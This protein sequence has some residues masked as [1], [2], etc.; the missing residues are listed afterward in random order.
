MD[1]SDDSINILRLLKSPTPPPSETA[2]PLGSAT[3]VLSSTPPDTAPSAVSSSRPMSPDSIILD[4]TGR[5]T[6]SHN[7]L[8]DGVPSVRPHSPDSL[9]SPIP[10]RVSSTGSLTSDITDFSDDSINILRLL[11][12]PTPPPS[13]TARPLGSATNVLTSTPPDTAPSAV[14]SSRPMSPDSIILDLTGRDTPSHNSLADGVPSVRPHSPDSLHSP[15]PSRVPSTGSLTSDITDS[16]DTATT[17]AF[18]QDSLELD[19]GWESHGRPPSLSPFHPPSVVVEMACN[20]NNNNHHHLTGTEGHSRVTNEVLIGRDL[21][22]NNLLVILVSA[23]VLGS[24]GSMTAINIHV[25]GSPTHIV[26]EWLT[27][28]ATS[29]VLAAASAIVVAATCTTYSVMSSYRSTHQ[30]HKYSFNSSTIDQT[31]HLEE[32][33]PRNTRNQK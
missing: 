19:D 18:S 14:S 27:R 7:S 8:V 6:P 26:H 10:S 24:V 29:M 20:H 2:R 21:S 16:F 32:F 22:M 5:D 33:K 9:H 31:K 11:K 17:S 13:E 12:S 30:E 15:I 28:W 1:F 4:L 25:I 23:I 3:S